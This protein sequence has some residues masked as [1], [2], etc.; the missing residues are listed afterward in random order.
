MRV[1]PASDPASG[2]VSPNPASAFAVEQVGQQLVLLRLGAEAVDRH[3]AEADAGLEG[4]R[5][6]LVD[7]AD[8]LDR[9]AE[10]EEV[11]ALPA[12]LLG[13]RQAEQAQVAHLRDEVEG[14]RVGAVRLVG[15]RGHHLFGELAH[16][17]GEFA[18]FVFQVVVVH[19]FA[20]LG[21]PLWGLLCGRGGA[22]GG[23]GAVSGDDG[24]HVVT[25]HLVTDAGG[26]R[27]DSVVGCD[28]RVLHLHRLDRRDAIA[29]GDARAV[30]DVDGDDGA[31]H[32]RAELRIG[33]TDDTLAPR[34]PQPGRLATAER[35][36]ARGLA[37]RV[38][39][40]DPSGSRA[41]L[42][43]AVGSPGTPVTISSPSVRNACGTAPTAVRHSSEACAF[44]T[45]NPGP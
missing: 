45:A 11:A 35:P 30:G 5:E 42:T 14:Q 2:S 34:E 24:E 33:R 22:G 13:E 37:V 10:G 1:A 31:G 15:A 32:R 26:E 12:D 21:R 43:D 20:F 44:V 17:R 18:F 7:A 4:D 25:R 6:R 28:D 23:A 27:D 39:P 36:Q 8:A 19:E 40:H 9:E 29:G 38:H 16:H 41:T 3:R